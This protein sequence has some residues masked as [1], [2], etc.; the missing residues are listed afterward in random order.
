MIP[1]KN[2]ASGAT[3][4]TAAKIARIVA[5]SRRWLVADNAIAERARTGPSNPSHKAESTSNQRA[6][7][8]SASVSHANKKPSENCQIKKIA[9]VMMAMRR[10]PIVL[11]D[12]SLG[13]D[14]IAAAPTL[15]RS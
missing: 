7:V 13:M 15:V 10:T 1:M 12:H 8:G 4:M 14:D 6:S 2:A 5:R 11:F 9:R 3:Y